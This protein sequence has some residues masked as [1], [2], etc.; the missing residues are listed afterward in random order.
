M[1][2]CPP[3]W[4]PAPGLVFPPMTTVAMRDIK[5][6]V[7]GAA[8]GLLNTNRQVGAVIGTAAVG[9]LLQNR[10]A[11]ALPSQAR[12]RSIGLPPPIR[13]KLVAGVTRAANSGAVGPGQSTSFHSQH[14]IPAPLARQVAQIYQASFT[15]GYVDAMRP[16]IVLPIAA[17]AVAALSC[18]AIKSGPAQPAQASAEHDMKAPEVLR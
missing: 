3:S 15:H 14:G 10:L 2:S 12:Q 17:L 7:A 1:T 6:H 4:W 18:L 9:A 8:S 11:A 16:A 5:P 13:D